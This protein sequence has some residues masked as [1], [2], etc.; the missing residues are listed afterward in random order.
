MRDSNHGW[1]QAGRVVM[2]MGRV[3]TGRQLAGRNLTVY[4][5]DVFLVSYPRSGN[6][7]TRFLL[8]NLISRDP[9]TF[10]NIESLIPEIY[11]N[12]D[13]VMRALPRPR[14]IKSH[15]CFQ[16]HY[17]HVIY[18]VRDPRDVAVSFYHHNVKAGNIPDNY[19]MG[20]FVPRFIDAEFDTKW[21]SWSDHVRS[22]LL[23]RHGKPGFI[24]IRYEDMKRQPLRELERIA[25][26]LRQLS[27]S[28]V[29]T[30]D[31]Q[32]QRAIEM[33][34]P[35]RMRAL[36]KQQ[37]RNWVLTRNTRSD[38]PFIRSATAGE[39]K[40]QLPEPAV[41]LLETAWGNLIRSLGY[42]LQ[43]TVTPTDAVVPVF[44][45]AASA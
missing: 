18:I 12:P 20:D 41:A 11:F 40:R 42:S 33:S 15:E 17:R 43:T 9:V 16:P 44:F 30:N 24:F 2:Q 39:W 36:E 4:P 23:L 6:T 35:E 28:S 7:W 26:F 13:R 45:P 27:F 3:I 37:A 21:G 25:A 1:Q 22:W 10:A 5:D 29:E 32:L 14:L 34:S 19:P 38:K 8:G 31:A